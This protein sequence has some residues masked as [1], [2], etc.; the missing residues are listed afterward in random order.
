M[1]SYITFS[2]MTMT[3]GEYR[4]IEVEVQTRWNVLMYDYMR[5]C[6]RRM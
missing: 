3:Y 5:L 4:M 2:G 6:E 1:G